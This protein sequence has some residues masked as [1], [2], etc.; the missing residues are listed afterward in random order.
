MLVEA[1]PRG[2]GRLLQQ[3]E[4][5]E[6]HHNLM[7]ESELQDPERALIGLRK[8]NLTQAI[9]QAHELDAL[10]GGLLAEEAELLSLFES[11]PS[12]AAQLALGRVR[13]DLAEIQAKREALYQTSPEAY[14]GLHLQ[15]LKEYKRELKEGRIVETPYVK[16]K[17]EDILMHVRAGKPVLIYG[18][19][20]SGK[21]E[22]A[23]HVAKKYL[24]KEALVI[25]GSKHT[26]LAELY[27][28][29]VLAID[30]I[31]QEELDPFTKNVEQKYDAWL[32]EHQGADEGQKNRA[33]DR[34]L[35][36]YLTKFKSGTISDFFLGP[37]YRAMEEGRP[38]I[39]DE[40]NAIPHEILISLNHILTRRPGDKVNVQQDSG[41][42]VEIKDGFAVMMTGN[43]NQGQNQYVERQDM[44]PAFLSRL[45]KVDYD[46]LPQK[47]QGDLQESGK[48]DELFGLL[49]A[50]VMHADGS[51]EAPEDTIRKLWR[52]AQAARVTQNLFAGKEVASAHFAQGQERPLL[53]FLKESVLSLRAIEAIM[54]QWQKEGYRQELDYY[55]WK[56]FVSQSTVPADRAFLYQL[57]KDRYGFFNGKGWEQQPN[58]G[59]GG[60]VNAFEVK[61]PKNVP[62]EPAFWGPRETVD[63]AFGKGPT[64]STWPKQKKEA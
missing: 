6:F 1:N 24:G 58:Y 55:L 26:S 15:E 22:L 34:I 36:I 59:S 61:S 27:G 50:R 18:H 12:G 40:V 10:V 9:R 44:D 47:T 49:L 63:Y 54:T 29:Q 14:Y 52:L 11:E 20:G 46:Y 5:E 19:L 41:K 4:N 43:L 7:A 21:T 48:G 25:S 8:K 13:K 64:R 62:K 37:I 60:L 2:K 38:I 30:K 39:I 56:E 35:Q 42:I 17:A 16:E 3:A 28:H 23:M 33:H 53:Y 32:Q 51:I 57:L 31:N 45:Y